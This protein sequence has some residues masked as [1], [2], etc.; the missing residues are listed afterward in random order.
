MAIGGEKARNVL[1]TPLEICGQDPM[2]GFYR[3]GCCDTGPD[4][5]GMHIVCAVMTEEFLAFSQERG[6]DLSTPRPNFPGLHAGDPWCLCALRWLEAHQFGVAPPVLLTATHEN[7][8]SII[9]LET[10]EMHALDRH[11]D[12]S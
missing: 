4:D 8:L 6:N 1:G 9:P 10:L 5:V 7:T 3:N 12:V 2:T 11:V